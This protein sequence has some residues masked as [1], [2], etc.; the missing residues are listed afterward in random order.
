MIRQKIYFNDNIILTIIHENMDNGVEKRFISEIENTEFGELKFVEEYIEKIGEIVFDEINHGFLE[1]QNSKNPYYSYSTSFK[2]FINYEKPLFKENKLTIEMEKFYKL[3]D[4]V[5][6]KTGYK[7]TENPY[8]IGN[9]IIFIPNKIECTCFEYKGE[10]DG[11]EVKGL[12]NESIT[13]VKLKYY[14]LIKETYVINGSECKIYPEHEWI[15]FDIEVYK[16]GQI[17]Y[18]RNDISLMKRIVVNGNIISK[19]MKTEL[20]TKQKSINITSSSRMPITVGKETYPKLVN[21]LNDEKVFMQELKNVQR[22]DLYF[23]GKNESQRA[24]DIFEQLMDCDCDEVWIFDPYFMDYDQTGG[25]ERMRDILKIFTKNRNAKKNIVCE[26]A[27]AKD[28]FIQKVIDED[29]DIK[30][31]SKNFNGLNIQCYKT[32]EHFHDRFTFMK[33]KDKIEGYLIGT[34][35]NSFGENYSTLI[36]LK[37]SEAKIVLNKLLAEVVSNKIT[38]YKSL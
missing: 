5:R 18:A 19:S 29:E 36:K 38:E 21:Y 34:S 17:V 30:S 25:V 9:T 32:S 33:N 31:I 26:A 15:S 10:I 12:S 3:C 37:S 24:F 22:K 7:L 35:F 14:D 27:K 8:S 1:N 11:I 20:K 2:E 23:L 16:R 13:I 28:D 6:N 4:F